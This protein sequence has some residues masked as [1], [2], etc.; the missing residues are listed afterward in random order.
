VLLDADLIRSPGSPSLDNLRV[1]VHAGLILRTR[2]RQ[3][4][5]ISGISADCVE[6]GHHCRWNLE[7]RRL[8]VLAKMREG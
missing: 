8:K 4:P 1:A 5:S 3:V 6:I 7:R 2:T